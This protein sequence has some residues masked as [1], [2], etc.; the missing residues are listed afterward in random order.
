[1]PFF[2]SPTLKMNF[3]EKLLKVRELGVTK[4]RRE[5]QFLRIC[6]LSPPIRMVV[7]SSSKA[8]IVAALLGRL[9]Y[10]VDEVNKTLVPIDREEFV[11]GKSIFESD[12]IRMIVSLIVR[13]AKTLRWQGSYFQGKMTDEEFLQSRPQH[14]VAK[15]TQPVLAKN[16]EPYDP[17]VASVATFVKDEKKEYKECIPRG[18]NPRDLVFNGFLGPYVSSVEKLIFAAFNSLFKR[19]TGSDYPTVMKG[20]NALERATAIYGKVKERK[21]MA[22]RGFDISHFDKRQCLQCLDKLEH[23]VYRGMFKGDELKE[24]TRLLRAQL[25]SNISSYTS[26]GYNIRTKTEGGRMSGD[27]NTSVGNVIV[28]CGLMLLYIIE[29]EPK[30]FS[31]IDDGD[32]AGTIC[33]VETE[34]HWD[35]FPAHM[36]RY[37]FKLVVE[38]AVYKL[39]H[40]VFCQSQPVMGSDGQYRMMRT[41]RTAM[42]KDACCMKSVVTQ[43]EYDAWR[44]SVGTG[45]L[46]LAGVYEVWDAYYRCF[47][48]NP[49]KV[50]KRMLKKYATQF[51]ETGMGHLTKGLVHTKVDF[52]IESAISVYEASGLTPDEQDL[53]VQYYDSL[54]ISK[55]DVL[56]VENNGEEIYYC[57]NILNP[58]V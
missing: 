21:K 24:V 47:L 41:I 57:H 15:Y 2:E 50:S 39:E 36:K 34:H 56:A 28:M 44:L 23:A 13:E 40:I 43:Q 52:T 53:M 48:R 10:D 37:G 29:Y 6:A 17:R 3:D 35:A 4:R 16:T 19:Y 14:L 55:F 30:Q 51:L 11:D 9:L 7:F 46:A 5:R 33:E 22:F 12:G 49:G 20:L 27:M 45:G 31:I 58:T 26:D 38:K 18:I 1:M 32:D 42:M 25:R 54:D 8:N